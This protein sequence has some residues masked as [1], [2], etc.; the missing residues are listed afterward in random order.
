MFTRRVLLTCAET[1]QKVKMHDGYKGSALSKLVCAGAGTG[2]AA[3][4]RAD[5]SVG[6]CKERPHR[7]FWIKGCPLVKIR[8]HTYIHAVQ[9]VHPAQH[10]GG[11]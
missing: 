5:K 11:Q 1:V 7:S 4:Q 9:G 10:G 2:R 3:C 8:T 6:A